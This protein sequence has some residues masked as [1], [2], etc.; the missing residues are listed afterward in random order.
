MHDLGIRKIQ[1]ASKPPKPGRRNQALAVTFFC[2]RVQ[3]V[4]VDTC[5]RKRCKWDEPD[6]GC[7]S[8]WI[9]YDTRIVSADGSIGLGKIAVVKL[10][11]VEHAGFSPSTL[12]F[13][14][15]P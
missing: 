2:L 12:L 13:Q 14:S 8:G 11:I 9:V 6:D 5:R 4:G 15:Y 1:Q 7:R 10:Q 3:R